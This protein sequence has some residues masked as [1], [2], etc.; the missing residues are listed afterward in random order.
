MTGAVMVVLAAFQTMR[1]RLMNLV[2]RF[3]RP[4]NGM[5]TLPPSFLAGAQDQQ[6]QHGKLWLNQTQDS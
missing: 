6:I 2:P 5:Y 3:T 4:R 1:L